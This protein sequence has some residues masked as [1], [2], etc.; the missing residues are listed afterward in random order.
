MNIQIICAGKL[1]E[2]FWE[3]AVK[4]YTKRISKFAKISVIE[5]PDEKIPNRLSEKE[6]KKIRE[7]EGEY[8]LSKI[9]QGSYI[10][11]LCV[12][13]KQLSSERFAEKISDIMTSNSN[14]AFII[15]G[16]I[17][18]SEK[19]KEMAD[20][21]ISFSEMTFPHQLMRVILTEQIY[22]AFKI[23]NKENYHK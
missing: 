13:S 12:E 7:K 11:A 6:A 2:N 21:R 1:K 16:S 22:R 19:V 20:F 4:E 18:L 8:I 23:M 3:D 17:G 10:I 15:G 5:V 14:I 9:K